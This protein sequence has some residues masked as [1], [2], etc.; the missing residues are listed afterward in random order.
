MYSYDIRIVI[1]EYRTNIIMYSYDIRIVIC[2]YASGWV[3][4]TKD[5][6][7]KTKESSEVPVRSTKKDGMINTAPGVRRGHN[8]ARALAG[9]RV[10]S[11][12]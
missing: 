6:N 3:P 10:A 4:G 7:P 11:A 5:G 8:A 12:C 1:C 2:E 9:S